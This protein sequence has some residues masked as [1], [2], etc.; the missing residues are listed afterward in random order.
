MLLQ[1]RKRWHWN[2]RRSR[3]FLDLTLSL[4]PP[5]PQEADILCS[6]TVDHHCAKRFLCTA[7]TEQRRDRGPGKYLSIQL[8]IIRTQYP[9]P[10]NLP[11][12]KTGNKKHTSTFLWLFTFEGFY[13]LK[14]ILSL[15][16]R[17]L[18]DLFCYMVS[19]MSSIQGK[20]RK[21]YILKL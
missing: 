17:S 6:C 13:A 4:P 20:G 5:P 2:S 1:R 7:K 10:I 9:F 12:W 16:N 14:S 3:E 21:T 8:A 19:A 11:H 15:N 18:V